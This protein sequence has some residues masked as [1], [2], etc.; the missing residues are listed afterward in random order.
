MIEFRTL[1]TFI[2][3]REQSYY[4]YKGIFHKSPNNLI[5]VTHKGS[6]NLPMNLGILS[7]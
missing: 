5:K 1:R 7:A 3:P 2:L 6:H 4:P